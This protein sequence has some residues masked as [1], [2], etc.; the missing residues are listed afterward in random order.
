MSEF[1]TIKAEVVL[2]RDALLASNQQAGQASADL[3]VLQSQMIA[4]LQT[5]SDATAIDLDDF[6]TALRSEFAR[7]STANGTGID[8]ALAAPAASVPSVVATIDMVAPSQAIAIVGQEIDYSA[9]FLD[10]AG[11]PVAGCQDSVQY[12]SGDDPTAIL[13][14]IAPANTDAAGLSPFT[15][16]YTRSILPTAP[17][18]IR[19]TDMDVP[20]WDPQEQSDATGNCR[21][22]AEVEAVMPETAVSGVAAQL[23]INVYDT[24]HAL[25]YGDASVNYS[26]TIDSSDAGATVATGGG[27]TPQ[28]V[29]HDFGANV[30]TIPPFSDPFDV[31]FS[32]PGTYTVTVQF[33]SV[34][35]GPFRDLDTPDQVLTV[36]VS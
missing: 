25:V 24:G 2:Q 35:A 19:A 5:L 12:I 7:L 34:S 15:V 17:L 14:A 36:V 29:P 21:V 30:W 31:V 8:P 9:T 13:P 27:G 11:S 6:I 26:L 22:V 33:Q 10:A 28:A 32:A 23:T 1:G 20:G 16:K 4:L 18:G 3:T